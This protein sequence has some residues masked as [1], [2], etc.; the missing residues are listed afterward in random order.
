MAH[1][2]ESINGQYSFLEVG[3]R[4]SA[5]HRCGFV[6]SEAPYSM[7]ALFQLAPWLDYRVEKQPVHFWESDLVGLQ[8]SEKA[9]LTCRVRDGKRIELGSVGPN[10]T[11][12]QNRAAFEAAIG[13]LVDNGTLK[14]ETSGVLRDGA[15]AF[16]LGAFDVK[17]FGEIAQEVFADEIIPYALVRVNHTGLR[18]IDL[19]LT[20]IRVVCANTL[21]MVEMAM[22]TKS[23]KTRSTS[24]RHTGDALSRLKEES[25]NLFG[26]LIDQY[27]KIAEGFRLLRATELSQH[28]FDALVVYPAI[29]PHPA[30]RIEFNPE[31]KR[32]ETFVERYEKRRNKIQW[33]WEHGQGHKGTHDAWEAYNGVVEAIDHDEDLFASRSGVFRLGALLDGQ[34]RAKKDRVFD[35][36][37]AYAVHPDE[38]ENTLPE[39]AAE[40]YG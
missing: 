1:M 30:S 19:A 11:V 18:G 36:L 10:Y 27:E 33:L 15:D 9:F 20:T 5:W 21:Q 26:T 39:I 4:R 29:G 35:T 17:Q 38:T 12:V 3:A 25:E 6:L 24:V 37:M 22:K 2:I 8:V 16:V 28:A 7:D 14:I 13:P 31:A 40:V 32:A 23:G 34:L